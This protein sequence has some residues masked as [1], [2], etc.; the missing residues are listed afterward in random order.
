MG[1]TLRYIANDILTSLKQ[2]FADADISLA[3]ASYWTLIYAD[4][5][6]S[7]HIQK[8]D[9]GAFIHTYF[10]IPILIEP[11]TGR[12][13]FELP[14]SIYD[15]NL[16]QGINYISYDY[17]VDDCTPP[18]T[19]VTFYRTTPAKA[20]IL[21]Y[22]DDERPSASNP[23]FY[24]IKNRVYLLGLECVN[25]L[26]LEAGLYCSFDPTMMCDLDAEFDFPPEL[27]PVLQ[28]AV[29]E[30]GRWVLLMPNERINDGTETNTT[31]EHDVAKTK[32]TTAAQATQVAADNTATE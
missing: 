7:Q 3:H 29:L 16:D 15:F 12:K 8:N 4:R 5:L 9:S 23:Y 18:F 32:L 30:L 2:K 22:T 1:A 10:Q 25:V 14:S 31:D 11:L 26:N 17:T 13:Y 27:I 28:R 21:Y 24:R 19:A 20:K 6:K